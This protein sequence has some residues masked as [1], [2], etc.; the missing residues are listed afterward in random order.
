MLMN[1]SN[2]GNV[3]HLKAAQA[4]A[5]ALG[6]TLVSVGVRLPPD[7]DAAFQTLA[8]ERVELLLIIPEALFL[9]ER[10]RI[11]ALAAAARLPT[12][13]SWRE[14]THVGGL[15]SY[16]TN[17]RESWRRSAAFVDKILKGAEPG[18]LPV[19][20]PTRLELVLNLKTAQ[21]LGLTVPESIRKLAS[22]VI[23]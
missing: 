11:V 20:F 23:E 8:Q 5:T 3:F 2:P 6:I 10:K 1:V 17:I 4:A 13:Y 21:A 22:E 7:I 16:G 15:I 12:M 18:D 19:E 9:N 14:A